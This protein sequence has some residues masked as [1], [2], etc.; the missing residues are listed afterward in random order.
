MNAVFVVT[1]GRTG[2]ATSGYRGMAL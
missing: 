2:R 1:G